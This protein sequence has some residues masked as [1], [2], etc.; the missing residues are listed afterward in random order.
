MVR[1]NKKYLYQDSENPFLLAL[2]TN[3]AF[4]HYLFFNLE[5]QEGFWDTWTAAERHQMQILATLPAFRCRKKLR[6][7]VHLHCNGQI[8]RNLPK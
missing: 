7:Q 6:F 3:K 4:Q 2:R 5:N 8:A 1:Q